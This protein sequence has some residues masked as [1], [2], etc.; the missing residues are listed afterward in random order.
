[1]LGSVTSHYAITMNEIKDKISQYF[2]FSEDSL[3]KVIPAAIVA[4][5]FAGGLYY[6]WKGKRDGGEG[7]IIKTIPVEE[8]K[9]IEAE[10]PLLSLSE[11]RKPLIKS[12]IPSL[13][14]LDVYSQMVKN[15]GGGAASCGYQ[16]LLRGMQVIKAKNENDSDE[17]LHKILNNFDTI[18]VY[19]GDNGEWRQD[20]ITRRK[21][22]EL[23][24]LLHEKLLIAFIPHGDD[25]I[26]QLYKSSLGFLEDVIIVRAKDPNAKFMPYD[27]TDD[28]I[29]NYLKKGLDQ[30]RNESNEILID[31]IEEPN[32]IAQ[33]FNFETIRQM[34]LSED[35]ILTIPTLI[36]E[37]NNRKD[38]Q[39]DFRGEWLSDG[40]LE[41]LWEEHRHDIIPVNVN[42]GFKAVAN[43]QLVD[44]PDIPKEFDEVAVYIDQNIKD[45]LNKTQQM[46]QLFA[47]GTMRQTG[48]KSGTRGHWYPLVMYQNKKGERDY[49]I[50]DS[51]DNHDRTDKN[52]N[53]WKIINLIE[54]AAK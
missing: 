29:Q 47:L 24:K 46:F 49:Y 22:Q 31:K 28:A 45:L 11:E 20:I 21:N 40:E 39:E 42:C 2:N 43:F 25:K 51:Y 54:K 13:T 16:T 48:E 32:E 26:I 41:Y 35:F 50:M 9:L 7:G 33:Y 6:W 15:T 23:K 36:N 27:F 38:L 14:Q 8:E 18:A 1:L 5:I 37:L 34:C 44:N 3:K 12:K 53:A 17:D 30:L 10:K 52:D 19:F 4:F